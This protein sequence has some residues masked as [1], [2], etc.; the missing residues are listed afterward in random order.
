MIWVVDKIKGLYNVLRLLPDKYKVADALPN[1]S[2]T[3]AVV[4]SSLLP[5]TLNR[6]ANSST[7]SLMVH[8][9][10]YDV[11]ETLAETSA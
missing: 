5:N 3:F 11:R 1:V 9:V 8:S 2:Q 6:Q 4:H 10:A 7:C